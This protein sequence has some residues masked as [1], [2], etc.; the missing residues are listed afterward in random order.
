MLARMLE[1]QYLR[2]IGR[3]QLRREQSEHVIT[4]PLRQH[5]D[6]WL[7]EIAR[8]HE[9]FGRLPQVAHGVGGIVQM[10]VRVDVQGLDRI[11][12]GISPV[13]RCA[14]PD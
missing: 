13:R 12:H 5:G 6:R 9:A 3:R 4:G 2:F 11:S 10:H 1:P 7:Y 14:V 8:R